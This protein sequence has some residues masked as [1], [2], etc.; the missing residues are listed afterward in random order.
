MQTH[1]A[2]GRS[3][4]ERAAHMV[5]GVSYL[6]YGAEIAGAH[7]EHYDG[8]GYPNG[9]KGKDIPL[10]ARIVAVVDVFDSLLHERPYKEPWPYPDVMSYITA[11]R[12]TQFDPEVVDAL[13]E[14]IERDPKLGTDEISKVS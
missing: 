9:L 10:S 6:H 4:L 8:Q 1:A 13:L 3:V 2:V 5:D 12:G 14:V 7:H 11:R